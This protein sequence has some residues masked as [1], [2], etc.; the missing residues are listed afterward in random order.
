M[1]S[2]TPPFDASI[3]V[4]TEIIP[5]APANAPAGAPPA[6]APAPAVT[7]AAQAASPTMPPAKA[8]LAPA[9]RI[10]DPIT[11]LQEGAD[12]LKVSAGAVQN[13]TLQSLESQAAHSLSAQDLEQL[14][15]RL[16]EKVLK[17]LQGRI[18]FV[19]EQRVRDSLADV[20]QLALIGL[21]NELRQGLQQTLEEVIA[22]AVTQEISRLKALKK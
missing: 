18:E 3:P 1:N 15:H 6:P 20:L 22:R 14:E 16:A 12:E 9:Q 8:P 10:A 21:T 5:I 17:Q 2:H 7:H 13:L 11:R 19:L 4:L